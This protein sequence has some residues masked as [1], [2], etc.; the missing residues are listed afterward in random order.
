VDRGGRCGF[1]GDGC[2]EV[3]EGGA[4]AR[5]GCGGAAVGVSAGL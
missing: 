4:E 3:G 5:G 1:G 2:E